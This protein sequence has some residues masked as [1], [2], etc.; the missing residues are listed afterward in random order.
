[1]LNKSIDV[2]FPVRFPVPDQ[3]VDHPDERTVV[4]RVLGNPAPTYTW[5]VDSACED[6]LSRGT[7]TGHQADCHAHHHNI[8]A[9]EKIHNGSMVASNIT[10]VRKKSHYQ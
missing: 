2:E 3:K 5:T 1:M 8:T 9:G 7:P 10:K 6:D 4:V